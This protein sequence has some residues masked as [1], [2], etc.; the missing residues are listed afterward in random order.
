MFIVSSGLSQMHVLANVRTL[1]VNRK[2][3]HRDHT[4]LFVLVEATALVALSRLVL[5]CGSPS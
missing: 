1:S 3:P 4:T 2:R 5:R